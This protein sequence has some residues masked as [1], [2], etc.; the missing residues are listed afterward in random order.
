MPNSFSTFGLNVA[1][2]INIKVGFLACLVFISRGFVVYFFNAF[3]L[4]AE[5]C[6]LFV[7]ASIMN[8]SVQSWSYNTQRRQRRARIFGKSFHRNIDVLLASRTPSSFNGRYGVLKEQRGGG[9][10]IQQSN[11][12]ASPSR[13]GGLSWWERGKKPKNQN[14]KITQLPS[15]YQNVGFDGCCLN[16]AVDSL[17]NN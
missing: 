15:H 2:F 10:P 13:I 1:Y 4:W 9:K 5:S 11:D 7:T 12:S 3:S 17:V 16:G 8:C 14:K 6:S